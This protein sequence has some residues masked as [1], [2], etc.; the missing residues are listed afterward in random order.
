[1]MLGD[2][3]QLKIYYEAPYQLQFITKL[4]KSVQE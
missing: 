3:S 1:M 4:G 2:H